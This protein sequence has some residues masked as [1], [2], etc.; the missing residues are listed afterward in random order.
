MGAIS[1]R[2]AIPEPACEPVD[3]FGAGFGGG[4]Y[5]RGG[6]FGGAFGGAIG[7]FGRGSGGGSPVRLYIG[8]GG[9][10]ARG[11]SAG[12]CCSGCDQLPEFCDCAPAYEVVTDEEPALP[13][14]VADKMADMEPREPTD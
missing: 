12:A 8:G 2:Q 14:P 6:A 7:G 9:G 5:L 4:R 1:P 11:L 10:A 13:N 3:G